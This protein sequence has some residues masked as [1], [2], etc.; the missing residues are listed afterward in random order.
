LTAPTVATHGDVASGSARS[1]PLRSA[2]R[3]HAAF[4]ALLA[5]GAAFRVVTLLAYRPALLYIDS[6]RY[7]DL[8]HDLDPTRSQPLGYAFALEPLLW[9]GNL[10]TV[11]VLQHVAGLLMGLTIYVVLLRCGV[12]PWLAALATVPVLLDAYQLQIEQNLMPEALFVSL[13]LAAVALLLWHRIAGYAALAAAGLALGAAA[14]VR[15]VGVPLVL[16]TLAFVLVRSPSGWPRLRRT[17]VL[18]VAFAVPLLVYA[19][20]YST[21]SGALG[22]TTTDAH[23]MYGRA[24]TIVDCTK[25]EIPAYERTLCPSEK[26]GERKGVDVYAH[27]R[28]LKLRVVPPKGQDVNDVLRDFSRRVFL[29]QPLDV[30]R[31]TLTDF[32]KGFEWDRTTSRGDVPVS[33]WQFHTHYPTFGFDPAAAG[34]KYG[35]GGP[36][37]N[38]TLASFLRTYQLN[39][40]FTPGPV[41]ALA[42]VAG[43]LGA[44]GIGRARRS[45][46]GAACFLPT[47]CGLVLL[48][49]ADVFEFSWR[50]QLPALVLAPFGGALGITALTRAAP[51]PSHAGDAMPSSDDEP[52]LV[53]AA[54]GSEDPLPTASSQTPQ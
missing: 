22:L 25:L 17:G 49:G 15:L 10:A 38:K 33:R 31:A 51:M 50:Y 53:L 30:V 52:S 21:F 24:A 43:L 23:D 4:V 34:R 44:A 26:L 48:L 19:T 20:Y 45:G 32:V 8:L 11:A 27:D 36:H 2:L 41:L 5:G 16:P 54:N 42:F 14:T 1:T 9:L 13:V 46:L 12:R 47:A 7:L 3:R 35:G 40:G 29:N 18:A 6:Y 28:T 39:I 37:T